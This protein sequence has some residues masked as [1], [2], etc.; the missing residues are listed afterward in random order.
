MAKAK[1]VDAA[2]VSLTIAGSVFTVTPRYHAGH[3]LNEAE[4]SALEQTRRE[5]LRNNLA[6]KEGLTQ[7]DV[8]E[9][10]ASY[11]FGVRGAI[12]VD[13]VEKM[14]MAL[15][16]TKVKKGKMTASEVTAAA[17]ELLASP[18]GEAIINAARSLA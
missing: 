14:A 4:A 15:A 1:H 11:E 3:V 7:E 9:Y 12:T 18:E 13:P 17:R 16:R 2:P 6:G 10:A 8:D 5:N